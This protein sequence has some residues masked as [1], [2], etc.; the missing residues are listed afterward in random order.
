MALVFP[1][2]KTVYMARLCVSARALSSRTGPAL[3][4]D[5]SRRLQLL[6]ASFNLG[7]PLA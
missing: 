6:D 3:S 4:A 7:N 1:N 5:F 2:F